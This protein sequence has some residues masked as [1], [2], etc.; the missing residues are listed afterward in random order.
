MK[1]LFSILF[2]L[3]VL[4]PVFADE[5]VGAQ[6]LLEK[7]QAASKNQSYAG[8]F[9]LQNGNQLSSSRIIHSYEAGDEQEKIEKLDGL[10]RVYVRRND[11]VI[12]YQPDTR[13]LRSEKR[14]SQDMF[15]AVLSFNNRSLNDHY[16]F[17]LA[18]VARVAG[19][20]CRM[21][22]IQPKDT[23]RYGYRLCA[24]IPSNLMVLAQTADLNNQILEQIA[25][26][27]LNFGP[28]DSRNLKV[29]YQDT[30]AW[31]SVHD[32][33]AVTT[34]SGW[35]VNNLP[36]GFRKMREVRRLIGAGA[37]SVSGSK[38]AE[39]HEVLQM[40]FSDGLA[41]V[42][43]FIEPVSVAHRAGVVRQGAT[44][45]AGFQ[46]GNFWVTLVGEVPVALIRLLADSIEYKA[47]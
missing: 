16:V 10:R 18:E 36:A 35:T 46:S 23:M 4:V 44:T 25:F 45:I 1:I 39:L 15:P 47:K 38:P 37:E 27:S 6:A 19:V 34:E 22:L 3:N 13:I 21:I 7:I 30:S 29:E 14:Q 9:V 28:V 43:V 17:R 20:D 41:S 31:K 32:A 33:V 11:D 2:L 24:A 26:T 40:V 8:I 12:S 42:S 5:T